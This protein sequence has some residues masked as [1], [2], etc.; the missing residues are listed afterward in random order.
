MPGLELEGVNVWLGAQH[1]LK[2]IDLNVAQ[3]ECVA[4]LGV[5][6]FL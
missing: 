6:K 1:V 2:N 5:Q 3:G 4:L